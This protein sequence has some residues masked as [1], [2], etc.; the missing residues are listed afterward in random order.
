MRCEACKAQ[1]QTMRLQ[2]LCAGVCTRCGQAR[3]RRYRFCAA[4]RL[5]MRV[6]ARDRP[7]RV[8]ALVPVSAARWHRLT[9]EYR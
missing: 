7:A 1:Q 5:K 9:G 4:C 3:T 8:S 2:R 6:W